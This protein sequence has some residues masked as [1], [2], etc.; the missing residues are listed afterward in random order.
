MEKESYRLY[1]QLMEDYCEYFINFHHSRTELTQ[2]QH[3]QHFIQICSEIWLLQN[4]YKPIPQISIKSNRNAMVGAG[5]AIN[6]SYTIS[7][8]SNNNPLIMYTN[9]DYYQLPAKHLLSGIR[10]YLMYLL[11]DPLLTNI[12]ISGTSNISTSNTDNSIIVYY[13]I[14]QLVFQFIRTCFSRWGQEFDSRLSLILGIYIDFIQ[15]WKIQSDLAAL[16]LNN[17]INSQYNN[18]NNRNQSN[19]R[20]QLTDKSK[21]NSNNNNTNSSQATTG[22]TIKYNNY[23]LNNFPFYTVLLLDFLCLLQDLDLGREGGKT[24]NANFRQFYSTNSLFHQ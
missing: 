24:R 11:E 18:N 10:V 15:P 21:S 3:N 7:N 17:K 8:N 12:N 13:H 14:D 23:V 1:I 6:P 22:Y 20:S 2:S 9:E 19:S 4:N 5:T 16:Q